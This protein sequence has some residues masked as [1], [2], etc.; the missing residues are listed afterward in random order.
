MLPLL[1]VAGAIYLATKT[2]NKTSV[3]NG[4]R[5]TPKDKVEQFLESYEPI[6]I[7]E[8]SKSYVDFD[9]D[10]KNKVAFV[11]F[12]YSDKDFTLIGPQQLNRLEDAFDKQVKIS[13]KNWT[14]EVTTIDDTNELRFTVIYSKSFKR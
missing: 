1:L 12:K 13:N 2:S 11:D 14:G 6:G 3:M 9:T 8:K 10:N 4:V 7:Y 5:S